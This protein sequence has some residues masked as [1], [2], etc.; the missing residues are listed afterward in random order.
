MAEWTIETD[1]DRTRKEQ[2]YRTKYGDEGYEDRKATAKTKADELE[3]DGH[4]QEAMFYAPQFEGIAMIAS[5]ELWPILRER[6]A[7]FWVK[8]FQKIAP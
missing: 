2:E 1:A 4:W 7:S 8:L 3:K 5:K 6:T